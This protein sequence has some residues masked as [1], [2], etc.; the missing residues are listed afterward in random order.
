M[1]ISKEK[2]NNFC[3]DME[4]MLRGLV[5]PN[6][7]DQEEF[8]S[9]H[10]NYLLS[11]L[12]RSAG[13]E[14]IFACA[15]CKAFKPLGDYVTR[16]YTVLRFELTE[17]T[18]ENEALFTSE[19]RAKAYDTLLPNII[20]MVLGEKGRYGNCIASLSKKTDLSEVDIRNAVQSKIESYRVR[21]NDA[22]N[23]AD[24]NQVLIEANDLYYTIRNEETLG[25]LARDYKV[26]Q[27]DQASI[28]TSSDAY[29]GLDGLRVLS[30]VNRATAAASSRT[31]AGEKHVEINQVD[32][33]VPTIKEKGRAWSVNPNKEEQANTLKE[34]L[35]EWKKQQ[36]QSASPSDNN[37]NESDTKPKF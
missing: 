3:D 29:D 6:H 5:G 2:Y 13:T 22:D 36:E 14:E 17:E 12:S 28:T 15:L 30:E 18:K 7:R 9:S 19:G 32:L 24:K 35:E 20:N 33:E 25:K 23:Y 16:H 21:F 34:A 31:D 11:I 1:P 10:K 37:Q 26:E 4:R 8:T 27:L